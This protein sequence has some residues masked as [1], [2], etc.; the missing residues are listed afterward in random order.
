MAIDAS[1]EPTVGILTRTLSV[2]PVIRWILPLFKSYLVCVGHGFVHLYSINAQYGW[3]QYEESFPRIPGRILC[4]VM[5]SYNISSTGQPQR[6]NSELILTLERGII[7]TFGLEEAING[8]QISPSKRYPLP[9]TD[10]PLQTSGTL[11]AAETHM[12]TVVVGSCDCRLIFFHA[13]P[14]PGGGTVMCRDDCSYSALTKSHKLL[15]MAF[16]QTARHS[17][18]STTLLL[19]TSL[20][21]KLFA[22]T[23]EWTMKEGKAT[24][25]PLNTQRI[26]LDNSLPDLLIPSKQDQVFVL[27]AST[28]LFVFDEILSG[29]A[30]Q[31]KIKE[32]DLL[33]MSRKGHEGLI[34]WISWVAHPSLDTVLIF[35]EDGRVVYFDFDQYWQNGPE[36]TPTTTC[37]PSLTSYANVV[38]WF[39]GDGELHY[40]VVRGLT[41]Q[42]GV[43]RII[44]KIDPTGGEP[45][46]LIF[47]PCQTFTG[48][49]LQPELVVS[50][51]PRSKDSSTRRSDGLFVAHSSHDRAD[52]I[53]LRPG[54]EAYLAFAL[55]IGSAFS[56]TKIWTEPLDSRKESVFLLSGYGSNL[57]SLTKAV[58]VDAEGV[59]MIEHA[60]LSGSPDMQD[61]LRSIDLF[62]ETVHVSTVAADG[63]VFHVTRKAVTKTSPTG[64]SGTSVF[65]ISD[66]D[67][68]IIAADILASE[69]GTYVVLVTSNI[70]HDMEPPIRI[71]FLLLRS[72]S[73]RMNVENYPLT[74]SVTAIRL[75]LDG[76][77]LYAVVA[78]RNGD[79]AIY[80]PSRP[81]AESTYQFTE[82]AQA[83]HST[84]IETIE[85]I[86]ASPRSPE[87]EDKKLLVL[88][89]LRNGNIEMVE[90]QRGKGDCDPAYQ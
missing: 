68:E 79:L 55:D 81:E 76:I 57:N 40:L 88:Y 62:S 8:V 58:I 21:T 6:L 83:P 33:R 12:P 64:N 47:D 63:S 82:Q 53:E 37:C 52:I 84:T 65:S 80:S 9:R 69:E 61:R 13:L 20:R 24:T 30:K 43:Y 42:G 28:G 10:D 90:L 74:A 85:V 49:A 60:D 86:I 23:L 2:S 3:I 75:L 39:A 14:Q 51:L 67:A 11:L 72:G 17:D 54:A 35:G 7:L 34:S 15:R 26:D 71:H 48:W 22:H 38:H 89:S 87:A 56:P 50:R 4:A 59:D 66:H 19:V 78:T 25:I 18:P 44:L 5:S 45:T 77:K 73:A 46:T 70:A 31:T 27:A 29:H 36:Y 41:G 16:L 32:N 1:Q